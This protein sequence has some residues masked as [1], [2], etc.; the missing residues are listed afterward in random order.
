M[1][2]RGERGHHIPGEENCVRLLLCV[3]M[4]ADFP[5]R[6]SEFGE[7]NQ[8]GELGDRYEKSSKKLTS[9]A[10]RLA[11]N[12]REILHLIK[13]IFQISSVFYVLH[14]SQDS[15]SLSQY[16]IQLF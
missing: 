6:N 14:T 7:R 2:W 11:L 9:T 4:Q 15:V 5:G 10:L 13:S 12:T 8:K 16:H 3:L 1:D